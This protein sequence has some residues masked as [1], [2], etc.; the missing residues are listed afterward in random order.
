MPSENVNVSKN[1]FASIKYV[2]L[3]GNSGSYLSENGSYTTIIWAVINR[4]AEAFP[5]SRLLY[6]G[7]TRFARISS[8]TS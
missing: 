1:A 7:F 2:I 6:S 8:V 3:T 5:P 4:I